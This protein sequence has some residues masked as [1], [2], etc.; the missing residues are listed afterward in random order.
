MRYSKQRELIYGI[1]KATSTHPTAN[2]IY[3][4]A[5]EKM[6]TISL[7]TVYRN[8]DQLAL[9]GMIKVISEGNIARYDWNTVSHQHLRCSVCGKMSDIEIPDRQLIK[10]IKHSHQFD[11]EKIEMI[12]MGICSEHN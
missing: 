3:Q 12:F 5:R 9:E 1:I 7:G 8:L 4:A 10:S 2:W 11:V 6:A